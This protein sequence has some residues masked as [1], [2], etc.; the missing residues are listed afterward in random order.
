MQDEEDDFFGSPSQQGPGPSAERQDS[1]EAFWDDAA[2]HSNGPGLSNHLAEGPGNTLTQPHFEE[3]HSKAES[4]PAAVMQSS[5]QQ[6]GAQQHSSPPSDTAQMPAR[7]D[8][9][10]VSA[11]TL[12][13]QHTMVQPPPFDS[14]HQVYPFSQS[15]ASPQ[16]LSPA[17]LPSQ[18]QSNQLPM[19][20]HIHHQV[21]QVPQP[22][23][24]KPTQGPETQWSEADAE[25][26]PPWL[27]PHSPT[28]LPAHSLAVKTQAVASPLSPEPL[29]PTSGS[30]AQW[31]G[32]RAGQVPAQSVWQTHDANPADP[33]AQ[34]QQQSQASPP[35]SAAA[36]DDSQWL[37]SDTPQQDLWTQQAQHELDQ[38]HLWPQQAQHDHSQQDV[39]AQ[40]AQ[41]LQL[42]PD[43][44][45][46]YA[47]QG[48]P[49]VSEQALWAQQAQQANQADES[50]QQA[51]QVQQAQQ[52]KQDSLLQAAPQ[53]VAPVLEAPAPK[54]PAKQAGS[55]SSVFSAL[56]R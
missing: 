53:A 28:A 8:H 37:Q 40:H 38:Q 30:H 25:P 2:S 36:Q 56:V 49:D 41:Q 1:D 31:P 46:V 32:V 42:G 34:M 9:A 24:V 6:P 15:S 7:Q 50:A 4:Y 22:R 12:S 17:Q 48:Q 26:S 19:W 21:S 29:Q 43:Q 51:L 11:L 14:Q 33:F 23:S 55:E 47:L 20:P 27:P 5:Q 45:H 44:Q 52:P 16:F 39:M 3:P 54:A 13:A 10:S 18:P 35:D